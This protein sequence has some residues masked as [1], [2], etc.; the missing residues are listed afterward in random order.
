MKSLFFCSLS[1]LSFNVYNVIYDKQTL[2]LNELCKNNTF[3][4][5]TE[6]N[7]EEAVFDH[8]KALNVDDYFLNKAQIFLY[9]PPLII[10]LFPKSNLYG[11]ELIRYYDF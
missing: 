4:V 6:E 3:K 5:K 10:K 11:H 2:D 8:I 9:N 1:F 7:E